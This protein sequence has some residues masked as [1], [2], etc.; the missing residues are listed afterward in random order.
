MSNCKGLG[1]QKSNKASAD[2]KEL[3][4]EISQRLNNDKSSKNN[5]LQPSLS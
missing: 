2:L 1:I 3:K 4:K 5:P